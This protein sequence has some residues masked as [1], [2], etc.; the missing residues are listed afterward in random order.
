MGLRR[1]WERW[2]KELVCWKIQ[3]HKLPNLNNK[4]KIGWKKNKQISNTHILGILEEKE[5]E[6]K[7]FLK[8]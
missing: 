4:E 3:Q 6:L 1:E 5:S 7:K 8:K 2:K